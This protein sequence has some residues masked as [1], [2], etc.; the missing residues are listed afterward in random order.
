M[1][2]II[3]KRCS[4]I[5][6]AIYQDGF[7]AAAASRDAEVAELVVA[8]DAMHNDSDECMDFDECTGMFVPI[9]EWN[10]VFEVL[11]KVRKP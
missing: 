10:A 2:P 3:T 8:L 4:P 5:E 1:N 9:D 11:A 6:E 7:Q